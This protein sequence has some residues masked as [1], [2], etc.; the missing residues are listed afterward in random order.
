MA[1]PKFRLSLL[2]KFVLRDTQG[3]EV[4]I[5]L[6]RAKVLLAYLALSPSGSESRQRLIGLLWSERGEA[7]ARQ[8]LRQALKELRNALNQAG[9][10]LL[11]I[12]ADTVALDL[13]RLDVDAIALRGMDAE[14]APA[15]FCFQP[16]NEFFVDAAMRDPVGDAWIRDRRDEFRQKELAIHRGRLDGALR[17][18]AFDE[19]ERSA[20]TLLL[21]DPAAEEAHRALMLVFVQ[22]GE[23]HLALRQYQSCRRAMAHEL[24]LEPSQAT[25]QLRLSAATLSHSWG[26]RKKRPSVEQDRRAV[27]RTM[28]ASIP[29]LIVLPLKVLDATEK[30]ARLAFG[31]VDD[32]VVDLSR[33]SL[34]SIIPTGAAVALS[35]RVSDPMEVGR[36]LDVK[37][38]LNGSIEVDE[39]GAEIRARVRTM[40]VDAQLG[41]TVWA[42]R[43]DR[44][45]SDWWTI[46]D[47]LGQRIAI[48]LMGAA[49]TVEVNRLR[50]SD[51]SGPFSAWELCVVAKQ[52]FLD[53]RR[54]SNTEARRH[55]Q[56]ALGIDPRLVRARAGIGWTHLE[57]YCFNWSGDPAASLAAAESSAFDALR[58]DPRHYSALYLKSYTHLLRRDFDLAEAE[59]EN[60]RSDNPN[61][62]ELLLHQGY[63]VSCGGAAEKG[64]DSITA[65]LAINPHHPNWY[66]FIAGSVAFDAERPR[67]AIAELT[68]FIDQQSGP[69]ESVKSQAIRTRAAAH[70]IAGNIERAH[71]DKKLYLSS[72]SQFRL[73]RFKQSF[74]RRDPAVVKRYTQAL[75]FLGFPD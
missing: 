18:E 1:Q 42:E 27:P 35:S 14:S 29:S 52:K 56:Q 65:A 6:L 60:A 61:D 74:M 31:L 21:L 70:A 34:F 39:R 45:G 36:A 22:R 13:A 32:I 2:G 44:Q 43:Y 5:P 33:M 23:R 75:E 55:Y 28:P 73:S 62:P 8:S 26:D 11:H 17:R 72:N 30:T 15:Q 64:L 63:V 25:E 20:Q 7:Q 3:R 10:D 46:R 49:E 58:M 40:L 37:Y 51:R 41:V 48:T 12:D 16:C 9:I 50:L 71:E 57:D 38:V 19:V 66:H 4:R 53:Y 47:D 59:C 68:R 54:E 67:L 24:D 69:V